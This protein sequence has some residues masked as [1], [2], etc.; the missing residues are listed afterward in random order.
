MSG[1]DYVVS[2]G[3]FLALIPWQG[4]DRANPGAGWK[5]GID[6]KLIERDVAL[7]TSARLIRLRPG[8]KTPTFRI[9][10]NT[11]I[12]VLSGSAQIAPSNSPTTVLREFDYAFV[13]RNFAIT[14]SN[15]KQF[16]PGAAASGPA[17]SQ[18]R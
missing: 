2:Q 7:G 1:I 10:A 14:L 11:H 12:A 18:A 16:N 6:V 9:A 3:K 15:P 17:S 5:Q 4:L 8:R 13:P